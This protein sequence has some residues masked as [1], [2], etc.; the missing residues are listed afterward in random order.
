MTKTLT[1]LQETVLGLLIAGGTQ[2]DVAAAANCTEESVSRWRNG[3]ALF[4]A[5]LNARRRDLW[6]AQRR[7]LLQLRS[8]AFEV[9]RE[10]MASDDE[11]IRLQAASSVIKNIERPAEP[12][13]EVNPAR[14]AGEL[15]REAAYTEIM[16]A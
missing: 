11:R 14:V 12:D 1:T 15:H 4:I 10:A 2:R 13:G 7:E 3:D 8:D 5:T 6:L 9:L 16:G